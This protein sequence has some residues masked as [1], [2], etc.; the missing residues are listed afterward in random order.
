[1]TSKIFS[2]ALLLTTNMVWLLAWLSIDMSLYLLYKF[3]RRDFIYYIP[4]LK[5]T[6]KFLVASSVR[7]VVKI[8]VDMTGWLAGFIPQEMG[9]CYCS[10]NMLLSHSSCWIVAAVFLAHRPVDDKLIDA[11]SIFIFIG[12]LQA[13]WL[14]AVVLF[15]S[16]I[17]RRYLRVFYSTESMAQYTR[18]LFVNNTDAS[19]KMVIL[20]IHADHWMGIRGDVKAYSLENWK[21]WEE[22][23]PSWFDTHFQM[24]VPDDF[25]PK[26]SLEDLNRRSKGGKRRRSSV[27][28]SLGLKDE[29]V[30]EGGLA[31]GSGAQIEQLRALDF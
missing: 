20:R 30:E 2:I 19:S 9:G 13:L 29:G 22:E 14:V 7:I 21:R 28:G 25:I 24:K 31:D 6:A 27:G 10:F 23:K 26:E 3:A 17:K 5:G 12:G 16:K 11:S 1:M 4:G 8:L 18:K 15:L